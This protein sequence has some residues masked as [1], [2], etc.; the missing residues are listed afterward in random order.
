MSFTLE[1]AMKFVNDLEDEKIE[2]KACDLF[3]ESGVLKMI[4]VQPFQ[5]D[6]SSPTEIMFAKLTSK[7]VKGRFELPISLKVFSNEE[8][9]KDPDIG[10]LF[11]EYRMYKLITD[12][13]VR[14]GVCPNFIPYIAFGCCEDEKCY[15]ITEKAGN[16]MQFGKNKIYPIQTLA[17]IYPELSLRE[18]QQVLFQIVYA[19]TVMQRFKI[20]HNDLHSNNILVMIMDEP[21][22]MKYI[23]D[24]KVFKI[25]TKY[26]PY[27]YDWD[28][29]SH[30]L[31]GKNP[32]LDTYFREEINITGEFMDI[33]DI[34]TLFCYLGIDENQP[35]I[36]SSYTKHPMLVQ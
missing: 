22:I 28:L 7:L 10:G 23:A 34:Y 16:G 20:S 36:V 13:I 30:T 21:V 11:Y 27:I 1:S 35:Y 29:G 19:L 12:L 5:K 8:D 32:K 15:L 26:I 4:D 14:T 18:K 25:Q 9:D 2:I 33:R 17:E 3:N 24:K 6:S 31:L